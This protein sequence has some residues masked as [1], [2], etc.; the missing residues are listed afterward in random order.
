MKWRF[1]GVQRTLRAG[2]QLLCTDIL[3]KRVAQQMRPVA[4]TVNRRV[5][6]GVVAVGR[7]DGRRITRVAGGHH[8]LV[9]IEAPELCNLTVLVVDHIYGLC[10]GKQRFQLLLVGL[11]RL[12]RLWPGIICARRVC[13]RRHEIY[14]KLLG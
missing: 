9:D 3:M 7:A 10:R 5:C 1:I 2:K 11:R 14:P 12:L 8:E 4:A 13:E 6:F